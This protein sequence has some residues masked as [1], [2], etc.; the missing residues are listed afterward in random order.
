[1]TLYDYMS[2]VH[3]I[4]GAVNETNYAREVA[5]Q[6]RTPLRNALRATIQQSQNLAELSW[7]CR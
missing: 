3:R 6:L 4:D 7:R 2:A 1:M 5:D